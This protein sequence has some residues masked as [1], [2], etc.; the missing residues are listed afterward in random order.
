M[1]GL[2]GETLRAWA[3]VAVSLFN[4]VL[5][6]WLG[7]SLWLHAARTESPQRRDPGV[8]LAAGGFV[9]GSL[10]FISHSALLLSNSW[11][12]TRSNTL[13]LAV[14][15]VPLL[16]LP[17][18]WY[19]VLLGNTGFWPLRREVVGSRAGA[20]LRRTHRPWLLLL[21]VI[22]AVGF[23]CLALLSIPFVPGIND[24][25]PFIWPF[26]QL[27]KVPV[28]GIPLVAIGYPLYVVLCVAL[29]VDT[30]RRQIDQVDTAARTPAFRRSRAQL[31][32]ATILLLLV[33]IL[34]AFA[35]V[36][37]INNTREGDYYVLRAD[38]VAALAAFDFV[39]ALLIGAVV[40]LLGEAM[41]RYEL[42]TGRPLP[43]R[44]LA[45]HWRQAVALA[46]GYG[47]VLGGALVLGFEPVYAV[48][49][50][51]VLMTLFFV[52]LSWRSSLEWR[53]A[54]RQLRPMVTS[55]GWYERLT[56]AQRG[57]GLAPRNGAFQ[58]LCADVLR[59]PRA[60]LIPVGP[61][62][63]FVAAQAFPT[64]APLPAIVSALASQLATFQPAANAQLAY[65]IAPEAHSGASWAVPL[66][67]EPGLTGWLLLASPLDGRLYSEEELEI[68]RAAGERLIDA[69]A[70]LALS[71]RLMALQREQ[72]A[73]TRLL[74][75][76][77][78]RV[79]HDEVLPLIHTA[80][81]AVA[82]DAAREVAL[83]RLS[84]AHRQISTLLRDLP[85][86]ATPDVARL[87]PLSALRKAVEGEFGT[88]FE[89]VTWAM[90]DEA[91]QA[92][93]ALPA[94]KA[95]TLYFAGRE[96]VRNAARHARPASTA[97]CR[98]KVSAQLQDGAIEVIVQD[99]GS[100]W[101]GR[102]A[103][104][105]GLELHTALMAI[106]GGS[107]AITAARDG[108]RAELRL[109]CRGDP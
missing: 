70:S 109:P 9:L 19:V 67:G 62:A 104:G 107:L 42:F 26:R 93:R 94:L 98:L 51:A 15:M 16:V 6:L 24:L 46:G 86:I 56:H 27:I 58:V 59:A 36:W 96:L 61:L 11:E 8:V 4:T 10:F 106:A 22:M 75:Q 37:A 43:Q 7:L 52:L 25:T 54:M 72:M 34:V 97:G 47:V 90:E 91:E 12:F 18:V 84:D 23:I 82:S 103:P 1:A 87:G 102:V 48:L 64:D 69:A 29:S 81:L 5:L 55:E 88:A 99:N 33:S 41:T 101:D 2:S 30:L 66:W 31:A 105:H 100:G 35:V 14:A 85:V 3:L 108:A 28:L 45:R 80:M 60:F 40:V 13:W 92:A 77:T 20:T 17:Y 79:L 63:S 65:P 83:Q 39:I 38:D 78:R 49:L 53:R 68:A 44:E 73:Q 95:E 57:P 89:S 50:T 74:D 76:Q 21:T 32:A 71:Q